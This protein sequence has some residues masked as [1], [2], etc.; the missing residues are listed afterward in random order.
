MEEMITGKHHKDVDDAHAH[1][2]ADNNNIYNTENNT[3]MMTTMATHPDPAPVVVDTEELKGDDIIDHAVFDQLLEMDD[4]DD[5]DDEEDREF[6]K[7]LVWKY[8]EQAERTFG[9]LDA[10][11]TRLD[12]PEL[13]RL[14]HFLKGSSA[15]LGL[16][17]IGASC[18]QLQRYGRDANG[19]TAITDKEAKEAKEAETLIQTLLT[20]MRHEY[21]KAHEYLTKFYEGSQ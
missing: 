14:G 20:E 2:A 3:F 6:S 19:I 5:D 1:T 13:S 8:F 7:S 11:K 15:A 16:I 9:E 10:A 12:F 18:E 17:K 21:N 4:D